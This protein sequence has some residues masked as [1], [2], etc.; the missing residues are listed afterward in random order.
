MFMAPYTNAS[1]NLVRETIICMISYMFNSRKHLP[2]LGFHCLLALSHTDIDGP[3]N[4][5]PLSQ[6]NCTL[7]LATSSNPHKYP[8]TGGE[9]SVG[10]PSKFKICSKREKE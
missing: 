3:S 9:G 2:V 1:G 10:Q 4:S 8:L 5:Y 7:P 6:Q